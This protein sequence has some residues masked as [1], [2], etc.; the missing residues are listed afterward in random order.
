M[1]RFLRFF[2]KGK[3]SSVVVWDGHHYVQVHGIALF[4]D[5]YEYNGMVVHHRSRK[6]NDE[7][8]GNLVLMTREHHNLVHLVEDSYDIVEKKAMRP[9]NI[10]KGIYLDLP[11]HVK[12]K[13]VKRNWAGF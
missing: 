7:T 13:K 3:K 10:Q 6:M 8:P 11:E 5:G 2:T 9:D 4:V 12:K 1:S